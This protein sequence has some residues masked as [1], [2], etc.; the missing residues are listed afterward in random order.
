MP[1]PIAIGEALARWVVRLLIRGRV[2][3]R[4]CGSEVPD[5]VAFV[6]QG[7]ASCGGRQ[8]RRCKVART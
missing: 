7:C 5:V 1:N 8:L 3:C 4:V 6:Q 2:V